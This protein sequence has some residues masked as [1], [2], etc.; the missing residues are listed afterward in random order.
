MNRD[1]RISFICT[2]GVGAVVMADDEVVREDLVSL[3]PFADYAA[4]HA[5]D[6]I[7]FARHT[8]MREIGL[9]ELILLTGCD[10]TN[11][12]YSV[13]VFSG[14]RTSKR[15]GHGASFQLPHPAST[16]HISDQQ[17]IRYFQ[18]NYGP[19]SSIPPVTP[20]LFI[21]GFKLLD[22]H[23]E[24]MEREEAAQTEFEETCKAQVLAILLDSDQLS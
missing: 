3:A 13:T 1:A 23:V 17:S 2:D 14:A 24:R 12:R 6:W 4:A 16:M 15:P 21:R 18:H 5:H 11:G 10:L 7:E 22:R 20:C 8:L 19:S 9:H